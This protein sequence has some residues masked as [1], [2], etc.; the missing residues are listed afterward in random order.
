[1]DDCIY[2]I[3]IF[4]FIFHFPYN[5][6]SKFACVGWQLFLTLFRKEVLAESKIQGNSSFTVSFNIEY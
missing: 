3:I 2:I 4:N 1:M 6:V 5:Y